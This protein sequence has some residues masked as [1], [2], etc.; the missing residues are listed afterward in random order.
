MRVKGPKNPGGILQ[1][2]P[3][4]KDGGLDETITVALS[5]SKSSEAKSDPDTGTLAA[6]IMPELPGPRR[7][8][9]MSRSG[10]AFR[11]ALGGR[12]PGF[13]AVPP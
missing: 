11:V 9:G 5:Y 3:V 8:H 12:R 13:T 4:P 2:L 1:R 7:G 6:G 10:G